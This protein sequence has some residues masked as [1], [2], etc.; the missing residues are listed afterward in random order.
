MKSSKTAF[1]LISSFIICFSQYAAC[2]RS[3]PAQQKQE[4]EESSFEEIRD[5][6]LLVVEDSNVPY[7][8]W[9][10]V[11]DCGD[12][13][14]LSYE[15]NRETFF[16]TDVAGKTMLRSCCL[17]CGSFRLI[18][19]ENR[20]ERVVLSYKSKIKNC[21]HIWRPCVSSWSLDPIEEGGAIIVIWRRQFYVVVI[22]KISFYP[23]DKVVYKI[24]EVPSSEELPVKIDL[25]VL[26]WQEKETVSQAIPLAGREIVFSTYEF[27]AHTEVEL[28]KVLCIGY[29]YT[30]GGPSSSCK[31]RTP[32]HIAI[33]HKSYLKSNPIIDLTKFRF[34]TW[35]D[36]LGNMCDLQASN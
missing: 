31:L 27:T 9:E 33:V 13:R 5:D 3:P 25:N 8:C 20:T 36:G 12:W 28:G 34:K 15:P 4:E 29:D 17:E 21:K 32:A 16:Y 22:E 24:A 23:D 2:R 14:A 10:Q 26:K 35:E 1:F 30:Y 18:N 6:R 7:P 11:W 19:P